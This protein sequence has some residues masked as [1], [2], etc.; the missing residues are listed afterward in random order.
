MTFRLGLTGSIGMGKTTTANLFAEEGCAVWDADQ[1]VHRL[2]AR[3][4]AAVAA[5]GDAFPDAV[6]NDEV[7]RQRLKEIL[8]EH[9]ER[10]GEL[11]AIVHPLVAEDRRQFLADTK[12]EIVVLDIPLLYETG[13]ETQVDAVVCVTAPEHIQRQRVLDRGSM[14]EG[15]FE[16]ILAKQVPDVEKR[17]RADFVIETMSIESARRQVKSVIREIES[18]L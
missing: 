12:A 3:H 7:D 18:R 13:G 17:K 5:V 4:G 8:N 15:E 14:T 9:P 1:A 2:Y 16:Q 10:F 6:I 11:E